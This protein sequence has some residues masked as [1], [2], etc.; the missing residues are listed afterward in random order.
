M[1]AV[2]LLFNQLLQRRGHVDE[3]L[4]LE[5][6][7]GDL[8]LLPVE[9]VA[10]DKRGDR[11]ILFAVSDLE[12]G[13]GAGG[14]CGG[15]LRLGRGQTLGLGFDFALLLRCLNLRRCVSPHLLQAF[16]AGLLLISDL[17]VGELFGIGVG[18]LALLRVEEGA[19][20]AKKTLDSLR[21]GLAG[22]GEVPMGG[23]GGE[24]ERQRQLAEAGAVEHQQR[25]EGLANL[26]AVVGLACDRVVSQPHR[27][28]AATR[29]E[30]G[31]RSRGSAAASCRSRRC[32]VRRGGGDGREEGAKLEEEL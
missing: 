12:A 18:P 2:G 14:C 29:G 32:G 21:V 6:G 20:G 16:V 27:D 7:E 23:G 9:E 10:I 28:N 22:E 15:T 1:V 31:V 25:G 3:V 4:V 30:A 26:L 24:G 17:I 11:L 19:I 5:H 8:A 13:V